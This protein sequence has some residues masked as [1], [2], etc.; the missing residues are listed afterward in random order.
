MVIWKYLLVIWAAAW[1][2][3]ITAFT[4]YSQ[5]VPF[6]ETVVLLMTGS[7]LGAIFLYFVPEEVSFVARLIKALVRFGKKS[8]YWLIRKKL[9]V[10]TRPANNSFYQQLRSRLLGIQEILIRKLVRNNKYPQLAVFLFV[11]IPFPGF[12]KGGIIQARVLR[13][14][15]GFWVILAASFIRNFLI[16]KG[17]YQLGAA[18][19]PISF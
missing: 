2:E 10:A 4:L 7:T 15:R 8:L 19:F 14:K 17:V 9:P 16:I 1:Q 13:L 5:G 3:H 18:F 6:Q 12:L 11:C